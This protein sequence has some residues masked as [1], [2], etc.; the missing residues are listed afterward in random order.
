MAVPKKRRS[1]AKRRINHATWKIE[2]KNL[3]TCS[4]C[5][6][7]YVSH[8]VCSTCGF[9]DGKKVMVTKS[10]K[11]AAKKAKKKETAKQ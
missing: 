10:E 5:G 11:S 1:K 3:S 8:T 4:N 7:P 6:E 2:P 9:Y